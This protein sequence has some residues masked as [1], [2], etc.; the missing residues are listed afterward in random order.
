MQ[1][2]GY[3]KTFAMDQGRMLGND[4]MFHALFNA[5][6]TDPKRE[7]ICA[8]LSIVWIARRI[9]FHNESAAERRSGLVSMGG[10]RFGGR[11][12]DIGNGFTPVD[13]GAEDQYHAIYD[14]ALAPFALRIVPGSVVPNVRPVSIDA[15]ADAVRHSQ[16]YCLFNFAMRTPGGNAI[17]TCAGYTSRGMLGVKSFYFFDCN[18]GEYKLINVYDV[19]D[20]IRELINVYVDHFGEMQYF[21]VIE[22]ERG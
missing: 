21:S 22:V 8:G 7:G 12:Q 11:T 17:H 14:D 19:G 6:L 15:V 3:S 13:G 4:Q 1:V 5:P 10:M 2:P 20:F 18:M 9:M 16:T